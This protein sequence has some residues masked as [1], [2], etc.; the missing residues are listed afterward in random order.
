MDH[1]GDII[2]VSVVEVRRRGRI[3]TSA[4][5]GIQDMLARAGN[6]ERQQSSKK[7]RPDIDTSQFEKIGRDLRQSLSVSKVLCLVN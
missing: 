6:P 3:L 7:L 5:K 2:G 1:Q 4:P